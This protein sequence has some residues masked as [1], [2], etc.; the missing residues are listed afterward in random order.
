MPRDMK[1]V[2]RRAV[3]G[4]AGASGAGWATPKRLRAS[5]VLDD[6]P[7]ELD[8]LSSSGVYTVV[9]NH[10]DPDRHG[11]HLQR[12]LLIGNVDL[13]VAY[14]SQW[15]P[16]GGNRVYPHVLKSL[17]VT[18]EGTIF[19]L[20]RQTSGTYLALLPMAGRES[21]AWLGGEGS[22]ATI[23]L[24]THGR[25]GLHGE[26]HLFAWARSSSAYA[27]IGSAWRMGLGAMKHKT[28]SL[29][30]EKTYPEMFRYLG[31]CSWEAYNTQIDEAK[32]VRAVQQIEDSSVPIRYLLMDEG[33]ADNQTLRPDA[34][35]F[36]HGYRPLTRH[37]NP[38]KIRWFGLWWAFL[39]AAHGVKRSGQLGSLTNAMMPVGDDVLIPK[40]D[41]NSAGRFFDHLMRQT[42]EGGFDFVKID[43]MVDALPLY[44]GLQQDVPTVGGLPQDNSRAIRDPYA[45][46][47]LLM[48]VCEQRVHAVRGMMNCNWHSAACLLN[49]GSSV[50]GRCSEDYR[51]NRLDSAKAHSYLPRVQLDSVAWPNCVGRPRYVP[52]SGSCRGPPDGRFQG[53]LRRPHLPLR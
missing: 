47:A 37:K 30:E 39:G 25:A 3:L 45:G 43:F 52:F 44:A 9:L 21:Y 23:K 26:K 14:P 29:R 18:P 12:P 27:A 6:S 10:V 20:I 7:I 8:A 41:G 38:D 24:G 42:V 40:S 15:W 36:P 22:G 4:Y 53:T 16:A 5:S 17:S 48:D 34:T 31:W 33:H 19:L 32:M 50:V 35:K 11:V 13:A 28:A 2:S 51:S 49:S 1:K 46:A